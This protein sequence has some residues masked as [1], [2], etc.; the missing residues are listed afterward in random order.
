MLYLA[1]VLLPMILFSVGVGASGPVAITNAISSDPQM[2]GAASRHGALC[3]LAVGLFPANPGASSAS[4]LFADIL[5]GQYFFLC[6][7]LTR[8][9]FGG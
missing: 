6:A 3:T 4:V 5:L 1:T 9:G 7:T 8:S 2:I